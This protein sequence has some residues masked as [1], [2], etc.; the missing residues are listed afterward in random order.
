MHTAARAEFDADIPE[1][2]GS[3]REKERAAQPPS[4]SARTGVSGALLLWCHGVDHRA[5]PV[6]SQNA[7][8]EHAIAA[9]GNW[10]AAR[11]RYGSEK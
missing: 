9:L 7:A 2:E 4:P 5:L 1:H 3:A 6:A 11:L 8:A 10:T